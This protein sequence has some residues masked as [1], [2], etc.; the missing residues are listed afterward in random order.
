MLIWAIFATALS[1]I[2]II[3]FIAYRRQVK[4]TC[5]HMAFINKNKT[6]MLLPSKLPYKELDELNKMVNETLIKAQKIT[7]EQSAGDKR[8]KEA[9]TNISH[10][11][12]TPLTSL[13][14]YFQLL[15]RSDSEE[16]R[17]KYIA[18]IEERIDNLKYMLEEL[19]TYTK[20]KN[21]NY[22]LQLEKTD[23]SKT[24][25]DTLF[26]FYEEINSRRIE[27]QIDFCD[28]QIFV[29][30]NKEALKRIVQNLLKNA[31]DH[32]TATLM[33]S[34]KRS[35]NEVVFICSNDIDNA[36]EIDVS[37]IFT[38][39]YKADL[40]RTHSSTGLGLSIAKELAERMK[41]NLSVEISDNI[42][43]IIFKMKIL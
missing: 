1:I 36:D 29:R 2:T 28:E 14:G 27:P 13:D 26:S 43:S 18:I 21:E 15:A 9:I 38:R 40:A 5:R 16:E 35:E 33:I 37:Q 39:F 20:L 4:D 31:F 24:V 7:A 8:L 3:L 32:G 17:Q 22:E 10:D 6:N 25:Y 11:I 19:F 30:G 23:F 41:G 12:R 34:M 42:F